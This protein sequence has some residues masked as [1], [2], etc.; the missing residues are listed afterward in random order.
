MTGIE[1]IAE[2]R[3]RQIQVE[4]FTDDTK[5]VNSDLAYAAVCYAMPEAA[6][7]MYQRYEL[8]TGFLPRLWPWGSEFFKPSPENR[9]KELTK[10]GALIAAEIDRL[11]IE[12]NNSDKNQ[13][14]GWYYHPEH[15]GM[16]VL[17]HGKNLG[18]GWDCRGRFHYRKFF[19]TGRL[20]LIDSK[21][22]IDFLISRYNEAVVEFI[23]TD[24]VSDI[25]E[26]FVGKVSLTYTTVEDQD[27]KEFYKIWM[28]SEKKV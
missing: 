4:G 9:I 11:K 13:N 3:E 28:D 25:G 8:G 23:T 26:L 20:K 16:S 10:A 21:C 24:S 15:P 12:M 22:L 27:S 6:R 19:N 1:L 5:Y 7:K 14:L 2:E 17:V 18:S